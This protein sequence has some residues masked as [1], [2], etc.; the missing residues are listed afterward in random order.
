M[1]QKNGNKP[2]HL[3]IFTL[4]GSRDPIVKSIK[5]FKPKKVIFI[6]SEE[7]K[8]DFQNKVD[9]ETQFP[10]LE[11]HNV[12]YK[13][14]DD[15]QNIKQTIKNI[16]EDV[17]PEH[18]TW[19][20]NGEE[21]KS[22]ID[23]TGG[24][25]CMSASLALIARNWKQCIFSYTGGKERDKEGLGVVKSGHE[26]IIQTYSPYEVLGYQVMEEAALLFNR[27]S[28]SESYGVLKNAFDNIKNRG[29]SA[30]LKEELLTAREWV[31]AYKDWDNFHHKHV[32]KT[33]KKIQDKKLNNLKS[34]FKSYDLDFDF[35][36]SQSI[37]YLQNIVSNPEQEDIKN[38]PYLIFDLIVNAN[39]RAEQGRFDDAVGRLYRAMEAIAQYRLWM[40]YEIDS[41]RVPISSLP[42]GLKARYN[43]GNTKAQVKANSRSDLPGTRESTVKLGLQEGYQFLFEKQDPLGKRF[44]DLGLASWNHDDSQK[45]QNPLMQRNHSILAHG[46]NPIRE[47]DYNN[48]WEPT[49]KLFEQLKSL[50]PV[51]NDELLDFENKSHPSYFPKLKPG[52]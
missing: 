40:E 33:L 47:K 41:S 4:G 18:K 12:V 3:V 17:E 24:T 50:H 45:H 9:M 34:C 37:A 23:I 42:A 52:V 5:E 1:N 51:N 11:K 38:S 27:H 48:L 16:K 10:D 35:V 15:C 8:K 20:G 25:K 44:S 7:S 36:L 49:V 13:V 30:T 29:N 2:R 26:K 43:H 31:E 19:I 39:R 6:C 14:L 28:Y 32:F 21:Y 22:L 46:F